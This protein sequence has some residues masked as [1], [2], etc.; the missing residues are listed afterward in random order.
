MRLFQSS[1]DPRNAPADRRDTMKLLEDL[2]LIGDNAGDPSFLDGIRLD[3][4]GYIQLRLRFAQLEQEVECRTG[5]ENVSGVAVQGDSMSKATNRPS[6]SPYDLLHGYGKMETVAYTCTY[7]VGAT[8]E[9]EIDNMK[10]FNEVAS[11]FF[12]VATGDG[13]GVSEETA[14][15]L[16]ALVY[17]NLMDLNP[18][19]ILVNLNDYLPD[20]ATS[21]AR[22]STTTMVPSSDFGS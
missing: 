12:E 5:N 13:P 22:H 18:E 10:F 15:N 1:I 16:L 9:E 14:K 11:S 20:D 17:T 4:A 2:G 19:R 8:L 7:N 21:E 6:I 3:L